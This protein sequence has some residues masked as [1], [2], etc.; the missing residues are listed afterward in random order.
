MLL[1]CGVGEDCGSPLNCKEIQPVHPKGNQ[2]RIFTRRTDAEAETPSNTLATWCKELTHLKKTDSGKEWRQEEKGTTED[3]MV[4]WHHWLDGHKFEQ[5]PGVGEG[6]G[7]L[8]YCSHGVTKSR[9][10]LSD[11]RELK[12]ILC[13][14]LRQWITNLYTYESERVSRTLGDPMDCSPPD[15]SIHGILQTKHW[16]GLPFP[17]P[18]DLPDPGINPRSPALQ[19]DSLLS[20]AMGFPSYICIFWLN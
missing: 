2:S 4:G 20:W 7:N 13:S 18:G 10:R 16:S 15:S 8:A 6:Q 14:D 11:W 1:N 12:R 3:E 17:S 9:T 5:A 19:A